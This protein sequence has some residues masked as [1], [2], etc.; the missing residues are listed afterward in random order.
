[1]SVAKQASA[2]PVL[3]VE[4]WPTGRVTGYQRNARAHSS[5]QIDQIARWHEW[6][7][8]PWHSEHLSNNVAE[9]VEGGE[10]NVGVTMPLAFD[11]E[12]LDLLAERVA[13]VRRKVPTPF[14]LEN[15]VYYF[16]TPQEEL[17]EPDLLNRLCAGWDAGVLLDLHNLHVNVRNGVMDA[18]SYLDELDLTN[19]REI[20]IAGGACRNNRVEHCYTEGKTKDGVVLVVELT[21]AYELILP[22][23]VTCVTSHVVA[24]ALGGRPIYEVLLE[25]SERLAGRAPHAASAAT[26]SPVGLDEPPRSDKG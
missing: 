25:R 10:I 7:G 8:F 21:G 22:L 2:S 17:T 18:A 24:E 23:M 26:S 14:L 9:H 19:V 15:N 11:R 3:K 6:L 12:T 5:A 13:E 1:M 16:E 20:H 4:T